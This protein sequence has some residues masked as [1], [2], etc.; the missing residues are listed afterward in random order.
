MADS[1]SPGSAARP[2]QKTLRGL[3]VHALDHLII[4]AFG[5]PLEC[6]DQRLCSI[7]FRFTR[8]EGAMAWFNLV[9]VNQALAVEAEPPSCRGFLR[10]TLGIIEAIEHPIKRRNARG[11]RRQ[12][13]HLQRRRNWLPGYVKRQSKVGAKIVGASDQSGAL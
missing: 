4:E 3:N 13:N 1:P 11:P 10:E 5:S 8:R 7:D 12:D 2:V 9:R 6:R